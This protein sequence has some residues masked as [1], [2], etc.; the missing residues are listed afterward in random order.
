MEVKVGIKGV[1]RELLLESDQTAEEVSAAV[2]AALQGDDD[3]LTLADRRGR[4]LLV[5][6]DKLAYIEI[7]EA[8]ARKVGFGT[9]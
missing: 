1:A 9:L 2:T 3:L 4:Q 7:G 6:A 5:P 8:E